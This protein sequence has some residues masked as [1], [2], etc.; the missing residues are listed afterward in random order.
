MTRSGLLLPVLQ[1]WSC[2]NCGGCC[3]E[4]EIG[5][6]TEEKRR[7]EQQN[8][9][10]SD[11]ITSDRPLFV[12]TGA[13]WRLSHQ[14]DGAC[15]FL[16]DKGLCRIHAKYGEA[17]KPLA[18]RTYPYALHPAAS[19]IAVSLR[20]S[21]PSVVQNAGRT[22]TQQRAEIE[23]LA[24]EIVPKDAPTFSAPR[25]NSSL[26]LDWPQFQQILAWILRGLN[27]SSCQFATRLIR[28]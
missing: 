13:G 4:H 23:T 12:K 11:G 5:I 14:A 24:R 1:S 2:H 6:S 20:F 8:W 15:V 21:C 10:A 26:T 9:S 17:A 7:I 19:G 28:T 25:L 16:D 27:D 3:R 22:V 18:C